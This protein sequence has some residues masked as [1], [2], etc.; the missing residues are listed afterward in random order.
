MNHIF[1]KLLSL[2]CT[3][4]LN[5]ETDVKFLSDESKVKSYNGNPVKE[6]IS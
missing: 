4:T 1:Q 6:E 2:I 5:D 3:L